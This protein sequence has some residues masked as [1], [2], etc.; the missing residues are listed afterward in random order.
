[1]LVDLSV[2]NAGPWLLALVA[3][4]AFLHYFDVDLVFHFL[5]I[6]R[7]SA[8]PK[9]ASQDK[10]FATHVHRARVGLRDL[11]LMVHMNNSRYL[12][13]ADF[14]RHGLLVESGIWEKAWKG[15]TPLVT[16]AQTIRYRRELSP[17]QKYE[18]HTKVVGW[19]ERAIFL[20]QLF[21]AKSKKPNKDGK[22]QDVHAVMFVREAV[23]GGGKRATE[24]GPGEGPLVRL[25]KAT[26]WDLP[27]RKEP[28]ADVAAWL[29]STLDSSARV[30]G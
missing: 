26:K 5:W 28:P 19:D 1:M 11:D 29:Q 9:H 20:E 4:A 24:E 22:F 3:L 25:F 7:P 8:R 6:C 14:A 18:V 21:V 2:A 23:A 10:F 30:I 15:K 17:F 27:P 16:G 12:R 13:E